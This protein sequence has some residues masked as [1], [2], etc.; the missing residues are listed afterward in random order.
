MLVYLAAT[1]ANQTVPPTG[2]GAC[3]LRPVQHDGIPAEGFM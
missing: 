3:V 2:M 1:K